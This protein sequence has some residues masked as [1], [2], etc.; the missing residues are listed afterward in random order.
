MRCAPATG[1]R[2][3]RLSAPRDRCLDRDHHA[4]DPRQE[5]FRR[6]DRGGVQVDRTRARAGRAATL[7]RFPSRL[8]DDRHR[9]PPCGDVEPRAQHRAGRWSALR[10]YRQRARP[11]RWHD[12][13]SEL[14]EA[15]YRAR[16][17]RDPRL[18]CHSRRRVQILRDDDTGPLRTFRSSVGAAARAGANQRRRVAVASRIDMAYRAA[19]DAILVAHFAFVLFAVLGAVLVLRW[20]WLAWLH[21]PAVAWA[22]FIE[23][24]GRICPLTPLEVILRR[25]A[26]EAGYAG[27]F[28]DHYFV[29]L[30]YPE[31]L[32]RDTQTTLGALVVVINAAIYVVALRR[33]R[34][35]S[36]R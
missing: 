20:P 17:A 22:A 25:Q 12:L 11:R 1:A 14:R 7:H 2:H 34:T 6:G 28:I 10:L 30:L 26:G 13:L 33:R 21:I 8:Q 9:P 15:A 18:R 5:R 24:G 29:L 3:A 32:T 35:S 4:A 31:V 23:F 16:L 19:A 36:K 27:S